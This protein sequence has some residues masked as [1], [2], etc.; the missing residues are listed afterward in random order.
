MGAEQSKFEKDKKKRKKIKI[1]FY[2]GSTM[3]AKYVANDDNFTPDVFGCAKS[4]YEATKF[5]AKNIGHDVKDDVVSSRNQGKTKHFKAA[6]NTTQ[7]EV[8]DERNV[9]KGVENSR[10]SGDLFRGR[11]QIGARTAIQRDLNGLK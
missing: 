8:D 11:G 5:D 1:N 7:A 2:P 4:L 3:A 10:D 9:P 6:L